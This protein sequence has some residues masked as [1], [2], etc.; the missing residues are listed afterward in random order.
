MSKDEID[1]AYGATLEVSPL[2]GWIL[3]KI[4]LLV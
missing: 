1:L 2:F 3:K 4:G